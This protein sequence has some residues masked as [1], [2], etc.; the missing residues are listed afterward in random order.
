MTCASDV[1]PAESSFNAGERMCELV[2]VCTF[3]S[4]SLTYQA[5]EIPYSVC[6]I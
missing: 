5:A 3:Y 6:K 1:I 4:P 2:K